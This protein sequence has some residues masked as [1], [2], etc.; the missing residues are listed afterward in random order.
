TEQEIMHGVA[1]YRTSR[2]G[3]RPQP[4]AAADGPPAIAVIRE[5]VT[6]PGEDGAAMRRYMEDAPRLDALKDGIRRALP[7]DHIITA[8]AAVDR[9]GRFS[10]PY[11]AEFASCVRGRLEEAIDRFIAQVDAMERA[12]DFA[13][14]NE[15]AAHV[16]FAQRKAESFVGRDDALLAIA[17]HV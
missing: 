7:A 15:R 13:L 4:G 11:L 16:A 3:A 17:R 9:A 5:L 12:P 1:E 6:A 2:D 14:A 10:E 8:R